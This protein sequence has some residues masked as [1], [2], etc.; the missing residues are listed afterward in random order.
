M[1]NSEEKCDCECQ[2]L[3]K[4]TYQRCTPENPYISIRKAVQLMDNPVASDNYDRQLYVI[5]DFLSACTY[6]Y[7]SF[8]LTIPLKTYKI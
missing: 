8:Y 6:A 1:T 5:N 3:L 2:S 4:H 7:V